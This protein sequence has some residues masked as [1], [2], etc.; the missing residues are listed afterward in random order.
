MVFPQLVHLCILIFLMEKIVLIFGQECPNQCRCQNSRV[1]C[2]RLQTFPRLGFPG[3]T[4]KIAFDHAD[5]DEIPTSAFRG[6]SSVVAVEFTE[7]SISSIAVNAFSEVVSLRNLRFEICTIGHIHRHAFATTGRRL[8]IEFSKSIIRYIH[9]FAFFAI[10][11]ANKMSWK[12]SQ[13]F[14]LLS[15]AFY[16][17]TGLKKLS[18]D[19]CEMTVHAAAFGE[20]HA[21][22]ELRIRR[23]Y[24]NT[25]ACNGVTAL[26]KATNVY[27][28]RNSINCD[29]GIEWVKQEVPGQSFKR[30]LET[31]TCKRPG[32]YKNV[33]METVLS[34]ARV[35]CETEHRNHKTSCL[36]N[37]TLSEA[38]TNV[39]TSC[40]RHYVH[41]SFFYGCCMIFLFCLLSIENM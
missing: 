3:N 29:C 6:L 34:N 20:I 33:T 18:F 7:C 32:E 36:S 8:K 27:L 14:N 22:Q 13:I 23:T 31:T 39:A 40:V 4:T 30:F 11:G 16:N 2:H 24:F 41:L 38:F 9:S 1:K 28:S 37:A 5:L 21:L 25:L 15:N 19:D 10:A 17:V 12:Q 35:W 26:F